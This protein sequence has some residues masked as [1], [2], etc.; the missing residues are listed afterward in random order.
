[1]FHSTR[2]QTCTQTQIKSELT[3]ILHHTA[4]I[5]RPILK[6]N[7]NRKHILNFGNCVYVHDTNE[8]DF[9]F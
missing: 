6:L 5:C 1:M 8:Q 2:Y 3:N 7:L 9:K 4:R